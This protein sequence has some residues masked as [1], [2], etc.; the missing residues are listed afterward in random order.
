MN[1]DII[2]STKTII[3]AKQRQRDEESKENMKEDLAQKRIDELER[4]IDLLL[5]KM[6]K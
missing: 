2:A 3:L 1:E 6:D 4:K 5:R